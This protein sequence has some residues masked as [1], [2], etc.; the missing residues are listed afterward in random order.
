[1]SALY[2]HIPTVEYIE[3]EIKTRIEERVVMLVLLSVP[4]L[5]NLLFPYCS[6]SVVP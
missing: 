5:G 2:R 6:C 4:H 3:P 1:M